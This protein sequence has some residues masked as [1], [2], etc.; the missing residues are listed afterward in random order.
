MRRIKDSRFKVQRL[1]DKVFVFI[2]SLFTFHCLLF[3]V[4]AFAAEE[5][6]HAPSWQDW[7]WKIV[8]FAILVFLIV[9]FGG[10]P[11]RE[12]FRKR[13]ELIEKSLKEAEEAKEFAKKALTEVQERLK[14]A[15]KEIEGIIEAA[16]KA[17]EADKEALIAE[18][19]TLKNKILEQ[20]KANIEFELQKAK[21]SIKSEAALMA[22]ELAEKDIKEKL[23]KKEHERLIEEYIKKLEGKN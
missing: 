19:E 4:I 7:L 11:I 10:K 18:G 12:F 6:E 23:S 21:E 16:K 3:T 20:T 8:N 9:K 2:F 13:T 17:G 15:D 22:L 5:A 14:G 1:K